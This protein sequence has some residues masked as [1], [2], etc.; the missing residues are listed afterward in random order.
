MFQDFKVA[1]GLG[2]FD[3]RIDC[4]D[5]NGVTLLAIQALHRLVDG[6]RGEIKR[7]SEDFFAS[8]YFAT[9]SSLT[10]AFKEHSMIVRNST[11]PGRWRAAIT[12]TI[13]GITMCGVFGVDTA[14][15]TE[16]I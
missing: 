6:L 14:D 12:V 4:V 3:T 13:T 15:G 16:S 7:P 9:E 2:R 11:W 8:W 1:F 10:G 5:I